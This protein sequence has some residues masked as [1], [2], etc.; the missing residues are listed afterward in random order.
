[1]PHG[2]RVRAVS[3][4]IFAGF[5]IGAGA[6][7]P[8]AAQSAPPPELPRVREEVVVTASLAPLPGDAVGRGVTTVRRDEALRLGV[9]S[10]IEALRLVPGVDVKAR[11]PRDVQTD[12]SIRG[13]TFGQSLV[14]VDGFRL[15]DS[16]SGHHNGE[17]PVPLVG[18]DRIEVVPGP[19]SAVHGAD[20]LGGTIN[21][22]TRTD[23][24][25]VLDASA[26]QHGFV[27]TQASFSGRGLP[28]RWAL[29]G[30]GA[31]SSGFAFDRDFAQGGAALRAGLTPGLVLDA[32]HQ[33]R[34][35]GANGF[36]GN[37][38]S[39]EW[40]DQTMATGVWRRASSTW[41]SEIR[42]VYRNHGDHFRWDINR[43]GFAENRHRTDAVEGTAIL[44]REFAGGR[45]LTG[46]GG[47]GGD[48]IDS[49][50]L[51]DHRYCARLR[52]RRT[53]VAG[54][55]AR[56]GAGGR[57]LRCL[58]DVRGRVDTRRRR[59]RARHRP[60]ARC[61]DRR[62]ARFASRPIPSSI[63]AIPRTRRAR[64]SRPRTAGRSTAAWTGRA[65]AGRRRSRRSRGGMRTSS[66]GCARCRPTSGGRRT[67]GTSTLAAS[68]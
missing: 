8:A 42:G 16:Q 58:L 66:T 9:T 49:S 17:I 15:N 26:G 20:A 61:A 21:V 51:G 33:R 48:W 34:A 45:R 7:S 57:A 53:A 18:M 13:A 10:I 41:T 44:R 5:V 1:M 60:R 38:P 23:A 47:G 36:Y 14:L 37:S 43:P 28:D 4:C 68:S 50:N 64:I 55:D 62:R 27:A 25:A 52:V 35:F 22:I 24:H 65:A 32:R 63:T 46:G 40:T 59:D 19:G 12:F 11:G 2:G 39:K 67:S 29:T 54:R 3:R 6:G 56:D 30:W 31:R